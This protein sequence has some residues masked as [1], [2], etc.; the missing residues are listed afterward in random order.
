MALSLLQLLHLRWQTV[1]PWH[2][3]VENRTQSRSSEGRPEIG[4]ETHALKVPLSILAVKAEDRAG[5]MEGPQAGLL[6]G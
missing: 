1:L 3:R 6:P 5:G 2:S 4:Q